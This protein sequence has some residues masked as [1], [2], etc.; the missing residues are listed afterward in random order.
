MNQ[1]AS[2][3]ESYHS[4]CIQVRINVSTVEEM[5]TFTITGYV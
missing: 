3:P 2:F 5:Y 4:P 1:I